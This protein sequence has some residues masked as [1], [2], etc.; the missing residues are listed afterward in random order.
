MKPPPLTRANFRMSLALLALSIGISLSNG[1]EAQIIEPP[2]HRVEFSV[3][4]GLPKCN[5]YDSFYG[6]IV[7]FVRV[8]SI[9]PTA[10]RKLGV[11][12]KLLPDGRKRE[13][14]TLWNE[15]G[16]KIDEFVQTYPATEECFKVLYWAAY[17]SAV[18]MGK[19]VPQ[20]EVEPPMSVDK[21][22]EEAEKTEAAKKKSA[23]TGT[24][25]PIY[26]EEFYADRKSKVATCERNEEQLLPYHATVAVGVTVGLTRMVMP[27][28][29]VGFG[30]VVG[31]VLVELNGHI[32]PPLVTATWSAAR[33]VDADV[34]A[35]TQAYLASLALCAQKNPLFGCA[36]VMGGVAGYEFDKPVFDGER[37][38]RTQSGG[39]VTA[40]LRVGVNFVINPHW[41]VRVDTDLAFPVYASEALRPKPR[42]GE[43]VVGPVWMGHL[44]IVPSW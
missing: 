7:N 8:R 1:A 37:F 5:E 2:A 15:Q 21:L 18:L 12:I 20:P 43:D 16:E 19:T 13:E 14:L 24:N 40:G 3:S 35:K 36:V 11:A 33:P 17:D 42:F 9:D 28:F 39:L 38:A 6:I 25:T 10:K 22:V 26:D 29:R 32:L 44:S 31:P 4:P 34:T 23:P 30:K 27:G 41:A